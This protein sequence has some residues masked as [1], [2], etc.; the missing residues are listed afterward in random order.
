M[1]RSRYIKVI[2]EKVMNEVFLK[3]TEFK[4]TVSWIFDCLYVYLIC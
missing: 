2:E 4:K 3:V 1:V